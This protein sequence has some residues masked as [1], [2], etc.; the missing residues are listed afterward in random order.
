MKLRN[1]FG[2]IVLAATLGFQ[3]CTDVENAPSY[4]GRSQGPASKLNV[5]KDSVQVSDALTFGIGATSTILG[6]DCDGDWTVESSDTTWV[7]LSNHAGYGFFDRWSFMRVDIVK[8]TGDERSATLTFKSGS[9]TKAVTLSQRGTG[10]DPNDPFMS[11]YTFVENLKIGYNLGN[12]LDSNP[13]GSWWNPEGKTPIDFE[14]QW[15]QPQT[16]P[17]IINAIAEKGFNVIRVPVTW[18]IH[19]DNNNVIDAAWMDRV[20]EVVKMVLNAGCYCILNVQHDTGAADNVWLVADMDKYASIKD[21]YKAIWTQVAQ[22]FADYDDHLVFEAF[23]EILDSSKNWND[24]SDPRAYEAITRLEQ[25]FVDAVRATGGKNLYRNL[26]V[27]PYSAGSTQ[28]KLDGMQ[29]PNDVHPNHILASV[30]SYDPYWFCNDTDDKDAGEKYYIT[31][32]GAEQQQEVLDVINRVSKRF[33]ELGVPWIFGEF[34]AIGTHADISERIK[35]A[36][37]V[38]QQLKARGTTGL[39]WMGLINRKNLNWYEAEIVDALM[40]GI[41]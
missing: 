2:M 24:P 13:I 3:G 12:T 22:R 20:E 36:R 11:A 38:T 18:G 34:G 39:W 9:L 41:Q 40:Q 29:I 28:A 14:T 33:G 16:T 5:M 17:E 30:H 19:M 26:M 1:I 32:F 10:T 23:N 27:N 8:N 6:V 15:G 7:K 31:M 25:D 35:Y 21:K 37:F 4:T